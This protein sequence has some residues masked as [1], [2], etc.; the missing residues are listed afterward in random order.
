VR[1]AP[2]Q[3]VG[4]GVVRLSPLVPRAPAAPVAGTP[5]SRSLRRQPAVEV[6]H[7]GPSGRTAHDLLLLLGITGI[8]AFLRFWDLGRVGFRGDEAVYAGQAAVLAGVEEMKRHFI[9]LSRGNSNFLLFQQILG[10]VYRLVGVADVTAR[11]VS[12][13]F[14]VLTVVATF[15]IA[16]VLYD[17]RAAL[18]AALF[19]AVSSYSVALGRLALLDATFAFLF[20]LS[21]LFL[22]MWGRTGTAA[23]FGCF[24]ATAALAIQAKVVGVLLFAVCGGYLLLSQSVGKLN[25]RT[26]LLGVVV[27][28]LFFAPA[29]LQLARNSQEFT[30]FLSRSS[31]RVSSVPWH[32][33]LT[34]L[35][36]YE[37]PAVT[38]CWALSV[39]AALG[40]RSR[41][42]LLPIIWT[43]VIA[44]FYQLY[45]LKAF[46]YMLPLVPALSLLMG[47]AAGS[48]TAALQRVMVARRSG[49]RIL[50]GGGADRSRP[51]VQLQRGTGRSARG[52]RAQLRRSR[53]RA[54]L[55]S[56][57]VVLAI[58]VAGTALPLR[59]ALQDDS[60]AGLKEAAQ[61]LA[62]HSQ[63]DAGV[64]TISHG[65][66]QYVFAFYA[67]RDSY[68]FGRFRL[69][70]VLPGG[71]VVNSSPT[72][73]GSTP[74]DWVIT[75]PP[76]LVESG[77]IS[78]LV[79]YTGPVDDPPE[80]SQLVETATQRKFR[81]FV[82]G[83]GGELV[84]TVYRNHEGRAWIY[85]VTKRLP[86]PLLA[87]TIRRGVVKLTGRG[88]TEDAPVTVYYHQRPVARTRASRNGSV[89]VRFLLPK[90]IRSEYFL[91][92]SDSAGNST[93]LTQLRPH[94]PSG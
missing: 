18:Y 29:F 2:P 52:K 74:R 22:A 36:R 81:Q 94:Q 8:A 6:E 24:A 79:Y 91:V 30:E 70:T 77:A 64:M 54:M 48:L 14:S 42:D 89:S 72:A 28:M 43:V 60:F 25:R 80:E 83:Y 51:T 71:V 35:T 9:L 5:A 86:K 61:W 63:P 34:T 47:R 93:S 3:P 68:P 56:R 58:L 27:F 23:W 38:I 13:T 75:W 39:V 50:S 73:D 62:D 11:V 32:Y 65:S 19:L 67:N 4:R 53:A 76:R 55:I 37:G 66:S 17:R 7:S 33:Y 26:V 82:E 20:T 69:A 44:G 49:A 84:H 92:A 90:N 45:P 87:Y 46:N 16:R 21:I 1:A 31:E 88:F 85:R 41:A 57:V 78:Y 40:R 12:A 59:A 10:L 15:L